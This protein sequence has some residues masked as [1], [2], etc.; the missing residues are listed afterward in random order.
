MPATADVNFGRLLRDCTTWGPNHE[1]RVHEMGDTDAIR[2][3]NLKL[4]EGLWRG[5]LVR[6][7]YDRTAQ[8]ADA[9]GTLDPV[10]LD[11][12]QG[13]GNDTAFLYDP[14]TRILVLESNRS[15]VTKGRFRDYFSRLPDVNGEIQIDPVIR[16]DAVERFREGVVRVTRFDV[17]IAGITGGDSLRDD[18]E[19]LGNLINTASA[20]DSPSL[21]ASFSVGRQWRNSDLNL[22]R[23]RSQLNQWLNRDSSDEGATI[24]KLE[25]HGRDQDEEKRVI[26]LVEDLLKDSKEVTTNSERVVT[27]KERIRALSNSFFSHRAGLRSLRVS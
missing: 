1:D 7:Y 6:I 12:H 20:L 26:D 15:G 22:N 10:S 25:M 17:K 24:E 4:T 9:N 11:D 16:P 13:I 21:N 19:A 27:Y 8:R 14:E 18:D 23:I 2:L 5:N 3:H